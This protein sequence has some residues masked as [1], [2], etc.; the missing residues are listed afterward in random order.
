MILN[1]QQNRIEFVTRPGI[2]KDPALPGLSEPDRAAVY[3]AM[4]G[5]LAKIHSV[6]VNHAGLGDYGKQ[7]GSYIKRTVKTWTRYGYKTQFHDTN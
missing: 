7:D 4:N 1:S 5:V 2:F 3:S 6:D